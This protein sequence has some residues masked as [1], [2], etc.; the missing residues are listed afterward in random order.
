MSHIALIACSKTKASWDRPAAVLYES[1]LYRK[2]L[3]AAMDRNDTIRILSAKYGLL[4]P[5]QVV[6]PYD[7]TLKRMT[8]EARAEWASRTSAQLTDLVKPGDTIALFAGEEYSAPLRGALRLRGCRYTEPLTNLALGCRLKRLR[9]LN[10][11]SSLKS[12]HKR[13]MDLMQ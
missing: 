5:E 13:F 9:K 2:S 12:D 7:V 11:E 8:R 1:S 4:R 10:D 6:A 3:L